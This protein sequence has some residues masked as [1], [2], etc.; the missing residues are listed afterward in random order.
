MKKCI[1]QR[2]ISFLHQVGACYRACSRFS[3]ET[4]DQNLVLGISIE[5][6]LNPV[7]RFF[8][9]LDDV[10]RRCVKEVQLFVCEIVLEARIDIGCGSKDMS[11]TMLLEGLL[12]IGRTNAALEQARLAIFK[13]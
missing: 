11:D 13:C 9:E 8:E 1:S 5:G 4:V 12:V 3:R 7:T 6:F 10:L 2:D